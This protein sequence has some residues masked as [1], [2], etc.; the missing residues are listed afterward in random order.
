M[1]GNKAY[2]I[3]F[4]VTS[5]ILIP[6]FGV[7]LWKVKNGSDY[8]FVKTVVWLLLV[9]NLAAIAFAISTCEIGEASDPTNWAI[10]MQFVSIAVQ[11]ICFN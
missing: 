1:H 7:L 9:S 11:Y 8:K 3:S 5:G 2:Y 4:Y 10:I 6:F